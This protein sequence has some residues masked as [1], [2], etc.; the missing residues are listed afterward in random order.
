MTPYGDRDLGQHWLRQWIVAWRHQAITW[1]NVDWSS[2]KCSDIHIRAISQETP[3]PSITEI[4]LKITYLKFH[5]NFPGANEFNWGIPL[6]IPPLVW[7]Q[8]LWLQHCACTEA[9]ILHV[10]WRQYP[11][12]RHPCWVAWIGFGMLNITMPPSGTHS[13][14]WNLIR[15][16]NLVDWQLGKHGLL[17]KE[18]TNNRA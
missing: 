12:Q 15:G 14:H 2:V 4:C 11:R 18:E 3:Q 16:C 1:T 9:S 5:S 7:I 10:K 6:G 17:H 13:F 8:N